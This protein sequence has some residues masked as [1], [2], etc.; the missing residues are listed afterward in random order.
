[1]TDSN[2]YQNSLAILN[3]AT[4]ESE[5]DNDLGSKF[6]NDLDSDQCD[7]TG[8]QRARKGCWNIRM[9]FYDAVSGLGSL[10][11]APKACKESRISPR[12]RTPNYRIYNLANF[13][14]KNILNTT[15]CG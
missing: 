5:V 9:M 10:Q 7:C 13:Q 2:F 3:I 1:M 12:E 8:G 15:T 4:F 14:C 11:L 6:D